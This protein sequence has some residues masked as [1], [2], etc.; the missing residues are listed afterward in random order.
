MTTYDII[1]V[2]ENGSGDG[3]F[4]SLSQ[5][6]AEDLLEDMILLQGDAMSKINEQTKWALNMEDSLKDRYEWQAEDAAV[7]ARIQV[8]DAIIKRLESHIY[9]ND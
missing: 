2:D 6:E 1:Y 5:D 4:D 9:G 7:T 8:Y 3:E